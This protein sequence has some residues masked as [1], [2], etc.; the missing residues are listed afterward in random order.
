MK[1]RISKTKKPL[2]ELTIPKMV[3]IATV[4]IMNTTFEVIALGE[5]NKVYLWNFQK[6]KFLPN[7]NRENEVL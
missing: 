3:T 1:P 2:P 6:G 4:L 5:D 7:W